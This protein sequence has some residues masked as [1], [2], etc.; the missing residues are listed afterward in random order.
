MRRIINVLSQCITADRIFEIF[1][2]CNTSQQYFYTRS[3]DH[4]NC[5]RNTINKWKYCL[6]VQSAPLTWLWTRMSQKFNSDPADIIF[7]DG[8]AHVWFYLLVTHL[9]FLNMYVGVSILNEKKEKK[10]IIQSYW[11]I[12]KSLNKWW[13]LAFCYSCKC[14]FLY[15]SNNNYNIRHRCVHTEVSTLLK[16]IGTWS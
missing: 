11:W 7:S 16:H 1:I 12:L 5:L 13:C 14:L 8:G 6:H 4:I 9:S 3:H 2:V 10:R 15:F